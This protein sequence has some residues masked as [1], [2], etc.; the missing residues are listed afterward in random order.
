M[1]ILYWR[2]TR[3][4][5]NIRVHVHTGK[6]HAVNLNVGGQHTQGLPPQQS[7]SRVGVGVSGDAEIKSLLADIRDELRMQT[8]LLQAK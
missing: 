7:M 6:R 2:M 3:L 8:K 4:R 5:A 1:R